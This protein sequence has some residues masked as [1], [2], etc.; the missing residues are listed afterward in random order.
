MREDL[1]HHEAVV[2]QG[3]ELARAAAVRGGLESIQIV[4]L[5]R[6]P[7]ET[8]GSFYW[9]F[10]D[11]RELY[12]LHHRYRRMMARGKTRYCTVTALARELVGFIWSIGQATPVHP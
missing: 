4:G 5:A 11:R 7:G 10:K 12:G 1:A 6:T 8:S 9:H 2:D 3:D